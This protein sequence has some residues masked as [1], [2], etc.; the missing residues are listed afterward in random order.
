MAVADLIVEDGT[1]LD[2][3]DAYIDVQFFRDYFDYDL[4]GYICKDAKALA[5]TGVSNRGTSHY[6]AMFDAAA[7]TDRLIELILQE[8]KDVLKELLTTQRVAV[9]TGAA[10]RITW[11]CAS[12]VPLASAAA[13]AAP[14]TSVTRSRS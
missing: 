12:P 1:G 3:A 7:S 10:L 8:D 14:V 6:T 5:A 13:A 4:A 11:W 9:Q 2:N